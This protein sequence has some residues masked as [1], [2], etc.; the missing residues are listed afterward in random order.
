MQDALNVAVAQSPA[1]LHGPDERLAWLEETV[2]G[3]IDRSVD[4]LV[5]PELFVCGYNVGDAIAGWA[6]S[7]DGPALRRIGR[8]ARDCRTAIAFGYAEK[9]SDRI[10]NSAAC[11]AKDGTV[12][13]THRKLL[14]P[15]GFESDHFDRGAGCSTFMIGAFTV[16]L[17]ICYDAEFPEAFRRVG[18]A[19]L[20][21]VPTALAAEWGVVADRV[22]PTRA[23]ENGQFVCYANHAGT[24][25][26]LEYLGRSCIVAPDG[27]DLARAGGGE[28]LISARLELDRVARA[29]ARLPYHR[30][31][32]DLP[33]DVT[34]A[35]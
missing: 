11:I 18:A 23:F 12:I 25:R 3:L 32:C 15:P 16:A 33:W 17:L 19:D 21:L 5:L 14:L 30:D 27:K 29:R 1:D 20:V 7:Q 8:L 31:R 34:I 24:E 10:Y 22:I 4:L 26:G 6:E 35:L 28:G 2:A 13:G 9:E